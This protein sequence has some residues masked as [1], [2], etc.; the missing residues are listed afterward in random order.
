MY[1]L[2]HCNYEL[3]MTNFNLH[4]NKL[5]PQSNQIRFDCYTTC[6]FI[7]KSYILHRKLV[8]VKH[9]TILN[10]F[11]YIYIYIPTFETILEASWCLSQF[12]SIRG[13]KLIATLSSQ[14]SYTR[15]PQPT[16]D[17]HIRVESDGILYILAHS[18]YY[19]YVLSL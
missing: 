3:C 2:N 17:K 1:Q 4:S 16:Y 9:L 14:K 5:T 8:Q 18:L 7:S 13:T 19:D 11:S 12:Y 15:F 10:L 6:I